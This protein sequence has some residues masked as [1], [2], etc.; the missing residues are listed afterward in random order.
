MVL[1]TE[2][3]Q[4]TTVHYMELAPH[5]KLDPAKDGDDPK[6]LELTREQFADGVRMF[7]P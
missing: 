7:I 5:V 3:V 1:K 2:V 4:G 6:L